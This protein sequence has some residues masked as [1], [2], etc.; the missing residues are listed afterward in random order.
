MPLHALHDLNDPDWLRLRGELWPDAEA[1]EHLAEMASQLADPARYA[2]FIVREGGQALGSGEALGFAEAA[3]RHDYVPGC[4]SSPV[5]FLEGLYVEPGVRHQ[6]VARRLV[7]AAADWAKAQG[8][9]ELASDTQLDN[10][11]SQA[12]HARLGFAETERVV[13]FARKL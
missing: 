5:G 11:L 8:C 12:V 9:T 13:C 10:Q 2:Q 6:G 1:D 7:Q 4:D 3:L